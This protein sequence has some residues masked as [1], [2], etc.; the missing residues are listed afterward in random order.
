MKWQQSQNKYGFHKEPV[1]NRFDYRLNPTTSHRL[2][3]EGLFF[4]DVANPG[5][6]TSSAH[7]DKVSHG[8]IIREGGEA[9]IKW[10][11]SKSQ[12]SVLAHLVLFFAHLCQSGCL[13]PYSMQGKLINM[14]FAICYTGPTAHPAERNQG[15]LVSWHMRE[16]SGLS[17]Y[18]WRGSALHTAREQQLTAPL[19]LSDTAACMLHGLLPVS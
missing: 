17:S 10:E 14:H 1:N 4:F 15:K 6:I 19:L 5:F 18:C 2:Q 12:C 3:S 11:H 7:S 13:V 16:L 9:V 8:V